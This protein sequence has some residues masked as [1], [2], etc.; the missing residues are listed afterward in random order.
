MF[1]NL[2]PVLSLQPNSG[3]LYALRD[4]LVA[5]V[6]QNWSVGNCVAFSLSVL[7]KLVFASVACL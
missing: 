3:I 2:F 7:I 5:V 6:L 1:C 4:I